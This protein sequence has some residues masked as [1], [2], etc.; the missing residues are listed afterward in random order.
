M[1]FPLK[2]LPIKKICAR[3]IIDNT[4]IVEL[5]AGNW[6]Y[7][8]K[9]PRDYTNSTNN[10]FNDGNLQTCGEHSFSNKIH[11]KKFTNSSMKVHIYSKLKNEEMQCE[12]LGVYYQDNSDCNN[13]LLKECSYVKSFQ[14]VSVLIGVC[15]YICPFGLIKDLL[16]LN[17]QENPNL[18]ID[19]CEIFTVLLDSTSYVE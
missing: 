10:L 8:C 2:K 17:K 4:D 9:A 16:L 3:K 14:L 5:N 15:Q 11:F 12:N 7:Y 6:D 13:N 1:I 18:T 19:I